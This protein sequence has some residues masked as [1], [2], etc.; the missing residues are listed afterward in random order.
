MHEKNL[1][2]REKK[3][4]SDA[5]PVQKRE[6]CFARQFVTFIPKLYLYNITPSQYTG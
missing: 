1:K 3:K 4:L 2:T 6:V 5:N